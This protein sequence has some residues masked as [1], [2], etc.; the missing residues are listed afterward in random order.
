MCVFNDHITPLQRFQFA[1]LFPLPDVYLAFFFFFF[2]PVINKTAVSIFL[3]DFFCVITCH[4]HLIIRGWSP[5][6]RE[7]IKNVT[8]GLAFGIS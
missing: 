3:Y 5:L 1:E 4:K 8:A 7:R 6:F 2:F